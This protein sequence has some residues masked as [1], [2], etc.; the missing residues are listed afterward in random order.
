MRGKNN[1]CIWVCFP[2]IMLALPPED[3]NEDISKE[4]ASHKQ[5]GGREK[6]KEPLL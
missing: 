5:C 2:K 3:S 1:I 6:A 4:N